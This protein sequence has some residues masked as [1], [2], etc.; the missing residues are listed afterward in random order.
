MLDADNIVYPR[1]IAKL[2]DALIGDPEAAFAYGIIERFGEDG[3]I[4]LMGL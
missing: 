1:G 2:R 3:G 4:D